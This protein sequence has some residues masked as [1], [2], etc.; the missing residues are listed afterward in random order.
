MIRIAIA[1]STSAVGIPYKYRTK[2]APLTD[3][4]LRSF[5]CIAVRQHLQQRRAVTAMKIQIGMPSCV[6]SVASGFRI[7][8]AA[9]QHGRKRSRT[10][11]L[12]PLV[13]PVHRSRCTRSCPDGMSA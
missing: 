5:C 2:P 7:G 9:H 10:V 4:R 13:D 8:P 6:V 11:K 12:I 3:N 1:S